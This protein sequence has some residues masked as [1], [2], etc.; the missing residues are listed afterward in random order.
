MISDTVRVSNEFGIH[1]RPASLLVKLI[2][3]Y[4]SDVTFVKEST[5][6]DGR[7][8]MSM[9]MLGAEKGTILTVEA[10]GEDEQ[11][12]LPKIIELINNKFHE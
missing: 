4:K 12:V 7:S 6:A 1:A 9:M 5:K 2:L 10:S 11:E 8:I 3:Q